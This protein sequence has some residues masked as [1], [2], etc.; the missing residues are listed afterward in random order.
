MSKDLV[1]FGTAEANL[2]KVTLFFAFG[3]CTTS[4]QGLAPRLNVRV[5]YAIRLTLF[6]I[7]ARARST[8][9]TLGRTNAERRAFTVVFL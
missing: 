8:A 9:A 3:S 4:G 7:Y 1:Q 2:N 5:C 6:G